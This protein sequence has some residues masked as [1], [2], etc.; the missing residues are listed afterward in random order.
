[1]LAECLNKAELSPPDLMKVDFGEPHLSI[2]REPSSMLSHISR[3]KDGLPDVVAPYEPGDR[4]EVSRP[5]K[6][7]V[8]LSACCV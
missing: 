4:I 5:A 8:H 7:P 6:I 1:M 3:N 2:F